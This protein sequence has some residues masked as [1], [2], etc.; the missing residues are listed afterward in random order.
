M[1]ARSVRPFKLLYRVIPNVYV[2]DIL[3]DHGISSTFNGDDLVSYTVH[4]VLLNNPFE[5]PSLVPNVNLKS[6][7]MQPIFPPAHKDDAF[8]MIM[9][10]LLG[11]EEFNFS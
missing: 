11:M 3:P 9:L 8:W 2:I 5:K 6:D 1:Q 4:T 10:F 7:P